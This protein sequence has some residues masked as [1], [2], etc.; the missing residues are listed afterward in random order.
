MPELPFPGPLYPQTLGHP[1]G[2]DGYFPDLVTAPGAQAMSR[3][4]SPGLAPL[5][6]GARPGTGPL[7]SKA[8]GKQPASSLEQ[9]MALEEVREDKNGRAP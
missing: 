7:L 5:T 3:Q 9:P 1:L 8:Q 6:E 4:P 2:A